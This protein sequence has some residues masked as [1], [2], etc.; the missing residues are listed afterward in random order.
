MATF[1]PLSGRPQ[2]TSAAWTSSSPRQGT[3]CSVRSRRSPRPRPGTTSTPTSLARCRPSKPRYRSSAP[4]A[5]A[6]SCWSPA[7]AGSWP[8]PCSSSPP[9]GPWR[10]SASPW[11]R[12]PP[13]SAFT[14]P[15]S[16]PEPTQ[17]TSSPEARH[18]PQ[19]PSPPTTASAHGALATGQPCRS[20]TPRHRA[21]H[22]QGRRRRA[23]AS[24]PHPR[25]RV[26]PAHQAG[27]REQA[28]RM[29]GLGTGLRRSPGPPGPHPGR[30]TRPPAPPPG[31][32]RP[33]LSSMKLDRKVPEPHQGPPDR[34]FPDPPVIA[35]PLF[36]PRGP[37][38]RGR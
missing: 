16:S 2:S 7:S 28:G 35:R 27:L 23:A 21:R 30:V 1:S 9:S 32:Q 34:S 14:S 18:A 33:Q 38:R 26:P 22:P 6:G 20:A 19:P 4:S 17:P 37:D 3:D 13:G 36:R 8:A 25:R 31:Q 5:T 24:A 11:P 12:R 10:P 15:L 29:G